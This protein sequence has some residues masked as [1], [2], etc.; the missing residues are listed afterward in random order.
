M[1]TIVKILL[2]LEAPDDP[3]AR[4]RF[5]ELTKA[6]EPHI[7][8]DVEIRDLKMVEDGTGRLLDTWEKR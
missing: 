5:R 4:R 2:T 3:A 8:A 1:R 7:P 6:L